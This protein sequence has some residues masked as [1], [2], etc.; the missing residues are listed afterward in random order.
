MSKILVI[1]SIALMSCT[2][3]FG[4]IDYYIEILPCSTNKKLE[5]TYRGGMFDPYDWTGF[6][7][8]WYI[9][10]NYVST[11]VSGNNDTTNPQYPAAT[12]G[13]GSCTT[14]SN[15]DVIKVILSKS[16]QADKEITKTYGTGGGGGGDPDPDPTP[17]PDL[18]RYVNGVNDPMSK[19]CV[20]DHVVY[21]VLNWTGSVT[22]DLAGGVVISTNS[23]QWQQELYWNTSGNKIVKATLGNGTV[24]TIPSTVNYFDLKIEGPTEVCTGAPFTLQAEQRT[25]SSGTWFNIS[26]VTWEY[27]TD[28]W[29][30]ANVMTDPTVNGI[31]VATKFRARKT[32]EACGEDIAEI[33]INAIATP[34]PPTLSYDY[35]C[36]EEALYLNAA[37]GN[38][39]RWYLSD[40]IGAEPLEENGV[41]VTSD[42]Y[43]SSL[44]IGE[45]QFFSTQVSAKGC[46]STKEHIEIN[47]YYILSDCHNYVR[48][49]ATLKEDLQED[50]LTLDIE[51]ELV[52][53]NT[54]YYDGLGRPSQ[55]VLKQGSP[56]N[57]DII[58]PR[59]YDKFGR[60]VRVYLPV[61]T[62]E[63]SGLYK[64]DILDVD[65]L[66]TGEAAA[67]Y[68]STGSAIAKDDFPF[69]D[70]IYEASPLNRVI[71]QGA[72]GEI[73]QPIEGA[74]G[75]GKTIKY[76]YEVNTTADGVSNWNGNSY[77]PGDN[78]IFEA[79]QLTKTI[80]TDEEGHKLQEFVD[81]LGQI[82]LKRVQVHES[83]ATT[84]EWGDTYY[85]YDDFG[86]LRFVLPPMANKQLDEGATIDDTF[87]AQ[88]A[89]CYKYDARQRMVE[90]RVPGAGWAFMIYDDRDRLVLSQDAN[91]RLTSRWSFTK[92]DALNRPVMTG[93]KVIT[94]TVEVLRDLLDGLDW[95]Q[96]Y[97]A[98]ETLSGDKFGYTSNSLPKNIALSEIY[99]VTYYDNY[100]FKSLSDWDAYNYDPSQLSTQITPQG[101]YSFPTTAFDRV[102]G[103]VTG[104]LIKVLDGNDT[105]LGGVNYYDDRYRLIQTVAENN[106][107]DIDKYS[108]LY[109]FPGWVLATKTSH[110]KGSDTYGIKK[111]YTYDHAG[112]L[113]QGY[114]ELIKNGISQ[115]EIL[116]AENKY[117]ELGELIEKNLHVE[118]NIPHQSIDYRYNIR[119][120]LESVNN[121]TLQIEPGRNVDDATPDLFGMELLYNHPLNGV[122]AGN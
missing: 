94:T 61:V 29:N 33:H 105:W 104:S 100:T 57:K 74:P 73:W 14:L 62:S 48:T 95:L 15:G 84:E 5:L 87:L 26:D 4:Q 56:L 46:E 103:Q 107:G 11:W 79:G 40:D 111:R 71:E 36:A 25:G 27:S 119:G 120:W 101:S 20:S 24:I 45:K 122:P 43:T 49:Y 41:V 8:K 2:A 112:R 121:S 102:K 90:K 72:P 51:S 1:A 96:N 114:H 22:W 63:F 50:Q 23:N 109:N 16:G 116:L 34:S 85:I 12:G 88:W 42:T 9:N 113:M 17:D 10:N 54:N 60:E 7:T 19:I 37:G 110:Q 92:Y 98:Y 106:S 38:E 108:T 44:Y 21:K 91:Q 75:V 6:T 64:S 52:S 58:I 82:V 53:V 97:A 93:E 69:M 39:Y 80:T 3:A 70:K 35:S 13:S 99:T 66:Y 81:K 115:G 18:I 31:H 47:S 68:N 32:F 65:G 59:N 67:F 83:G 77:I 76:A 118:N 117:N 55:S 86:N 28:N 78:G 30:T 89:F